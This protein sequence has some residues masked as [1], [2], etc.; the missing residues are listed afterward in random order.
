MQKLSPQPQEKLLVLHQV[1]TD[2]DA[3][4]K[5]NDIPAQAGHKGNGCCSAHVFADPAH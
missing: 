5:I 3:D 4:D 1:N 2:D